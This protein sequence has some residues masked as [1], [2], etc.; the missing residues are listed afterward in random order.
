MPKNKKEEY[1]QDS[2]IYIFLLTTLVILIESL[3][4]YSFSF[5]GFSLSYTIFLLPFTYLI[6]NYITKKYGSKKCILGISISSLFLVIF[7]ITMTFA[8]AEQIDF[9]SITGDF[10]GYIISQLVNL[11]IY[12]FL[13]NNT[14]SPI[15]IVYLSYLFSIVIYYLFYTLIYLDMIILDNYWGTYLL[16][17]GIDSLICIPITIIDKK[18]KRGLEKIKI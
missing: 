1:Y 18:I 13:L 12:N 17:I 2:W 16:T 7:Y 14:N 8:M 11:T 9:N 4:T 15:Y 5:K 6:S 3:K 10:C